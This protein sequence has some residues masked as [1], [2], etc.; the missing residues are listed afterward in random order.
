[1]K[2]LTKIVK[3]V[4]VV[5]AMPFA[6][7]LLPY[8]MYRQQAEARNRAWAEAHARHMADILVPRIR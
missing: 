4:A 5:V 7:A 1:M 2:T 3:G 6:L 8:A